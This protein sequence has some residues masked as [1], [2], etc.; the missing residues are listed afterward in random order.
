MNHNAQASSKVS[1]TGKQRKIVDS[2][3]VSR[4]QEFLC[5]HAQESLSE[6]FSPIESMTILSFPLT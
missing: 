1:G 4:R 3:P 6:I 2:Y 5:H